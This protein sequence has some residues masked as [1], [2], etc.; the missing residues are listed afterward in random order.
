MALSD[1]LPGCEPD[2]GLTA[3]QERDAA[4]KYDDTVRRLR[5]GPGGSAAADAFIR[6]EHRKYH[7]WRREAVRKRDAR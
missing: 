4:R 7:E 3:K 6:D 2:N 1:W 5:K